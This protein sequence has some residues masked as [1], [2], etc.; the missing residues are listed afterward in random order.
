MLEFNGYKILYEV[1]SLPKGKWAIVIEIMRTQDGAL[2][3][4]RHNPFPHQSFDTKLEAL[5]QV[6]RYL[7]D[8][9]EQ[10]DGEARAARRA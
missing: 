4:K 3:A 5:H 2:I 6:N 9:L 10:N 8:M 1:Q 7:K